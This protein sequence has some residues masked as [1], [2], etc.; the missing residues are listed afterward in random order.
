VALGVY[1]S[2]MKNTGILH[3]GQ[4]T[5]HAKKPDADFCEFVNSLFL[6]DLFIIKSWHEGCNH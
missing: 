4:M 1:G 5:V 6:K 3:A 2:D